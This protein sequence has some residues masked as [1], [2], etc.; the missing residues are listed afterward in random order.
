VI[1]LNSFE[2]IDTSTKQTID[3]Y[4]QFISQLVKGIFIFKNKDKEI[5]NIVDKCNVDT[6]ICNRLSIIQT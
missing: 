6:E 5:K 4:L 2:D 3:N 1:Y